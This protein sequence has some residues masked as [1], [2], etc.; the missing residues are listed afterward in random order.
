MNFC[1]FCPSRK[2]CR[3][4]CE[5][6]RIYADQD[7]VSFNR[8]ILTGQIDQ[9]DGELGQLPIHEILMRVNRLPGADRAI[10]ILHY[11]HGYTMEKIHTMLFLTYRQVQYVLREKHRDLFQ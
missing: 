10:F 5:K 7:K 9:M 4:L 2:T 1:E 3:E 6:A 8:I 11:I